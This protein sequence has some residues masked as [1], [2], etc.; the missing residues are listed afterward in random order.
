MSGSLDLCRLLMEDKGKERHLP[1][2]IICYSTSERP[3]RESIGA[4]K[5]K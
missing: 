3:A 1:F 5:I 2:M 4:Q